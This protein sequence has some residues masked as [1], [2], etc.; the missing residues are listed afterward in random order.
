MQNQRLAPIVS[1]K[2]WFQLSKSMNSPNLFITL[3][4]V[5][6]RQV[7]VC[8]SEKIIEGSFDDK[9]NSTASDAGRGRCRTDQF[10]EWG[11]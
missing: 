7:S 9:E 11:S 10:L 3:S 2:H 6:N 8:S 4:I 1:L 5:L